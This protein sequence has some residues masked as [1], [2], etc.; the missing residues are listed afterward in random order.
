MRKKEQVK[1]WIRQNCFGCKELHTS[2][3]QY[4]IAIECDCSRRTV[5]TAIAELR[6]DQQM[7]AGEYHG[8]TW[9]K[10]EEVIGLGMDNIPTMLTT[11]ET[12]AFEQYGIE[13][14]Y[15]FNVIRF[16]SDVFR[17]VYHPYGTM[18]AKGQA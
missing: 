3:W 4:R 18:I 11:L 14:R 6:R 10:V 7:T 1:A 12:R 9:L 8:R 17:F 15:L 5:Q 16:N 13:S 2:Y